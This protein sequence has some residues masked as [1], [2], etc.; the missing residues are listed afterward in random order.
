MIPAPG[1]QLRKTQGLQ[2]KQNKSSKTRQTLNWRRPPIHLPIAR[3]HPLHLAMNYSDSVSRRVNLL[4]GQCV[5]MQRT[6]AVFLLLVAGAV[7]PTPEVSRVLLRRRLVTSAAST[8]TVTVGAMV[9]HWAFY[10]S[11]RRPTLFPMRDAEPAMTDPDRF[12]CRL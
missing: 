2:P 4:V 7:Q 12:Q 8:T 6:T 9:V 1:L 11:Y 10:S 5:A 3:Q